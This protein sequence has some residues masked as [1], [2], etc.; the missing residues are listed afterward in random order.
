MCC[1]CRHDNFRCSYPGIFCLGSLPLDKRTV[2]KMA[3][4]WENPPYV[5]WNIN[6]TIPAKEKLQ[7]RFPGQDLEEVVQNHIVNVGY[8]IY[9]YNDI[10]NDCV[11]DCFGEVWDRSIDRA[12]GVDKDELLKEPTLKVY[13][14]PD[15]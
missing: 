11:Q 13:A 12:I 10:G 15:P 1:P 5:P 9:F 2:M 3:L 6:F 14:F 8:D 7:S 4:E